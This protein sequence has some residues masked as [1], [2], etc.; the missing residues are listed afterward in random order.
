MGTLTRLET[1]EH[2]LALEQAASSLALASI[3][4]QAKTVLSRM[5]AD[6]YLLEAEEKVALLEQLR[7][8]VAQYPQ[9][10]ELRVLFAMA[11]CVN[12]NVQEAIEELREA[13]RLAPNSFI[14]QLKLGEL[15]MR[16][17]APGKA[18]EH[19]RCAGLLAENMAQADL[20]RRQAAAIRKMQREG[21][22]RGGYKTI[23]LRPLSPLRNLWARRRPEVALDLS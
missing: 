19:T 9:V 13:V 1:Q 7:E 22:E 20:A 12:L 23:W 5:F 6:P 3:P 2:S 8:C 17:R 15:W 14:A 11:L 4:Q 18:E 16:L 10:S 21:I